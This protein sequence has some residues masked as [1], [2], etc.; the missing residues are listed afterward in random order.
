MHAVRVILGMILCSCASLMAQHMK[1][2][3]KVS[4]SAFKDSEKIPSKHTCDGK[5][6]SPSLQWDTLPLGTEALAIVVDDPDAPSGTFDHW[7]A[8][9]ITPQQTLAEGVH[10]DHQGTNGFGVSRY[11]GPCPPRGKPHRYFFKVYAL[12]QKIDLPDGSDKSELEKAME[13][14]ILGQGVL[15]GTYQRGE[16]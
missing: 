5:D 16:Q 11:R 3:M 9:N 12:S 7:L 2:T 4:S 6:I 10:L 13:G 14:L 8:W 1:D 15:M